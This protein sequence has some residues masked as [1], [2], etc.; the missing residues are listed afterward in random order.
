MSQSSTTNH[1][2]GETPATK[3]QKNPFLTYIDGSAPSVDKLPVTQLADQTPSNFDVS[4]DDYYKTHVAP[5]VVEAKT[6]CKMMAIMLESMSDADAA[7]EVKAYCYATL[8][9][10]FDKLF[11][12]NRLPP[13]EDKADAPASEGRK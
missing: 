2:K 10:D 13:H 9:P 12:P 5:L 8:V 6:M 3:Q 7:E 1:T 11:G 4:T